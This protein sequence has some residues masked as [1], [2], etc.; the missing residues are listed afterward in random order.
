MARR[1]NMSRRPRRLPVWLIPAVCAVFAG[2]CI[3]WASQYGLTDA[4]PLT[5]LPS[6]QALPV[7]HADRPP[8][9]AVAFT[10]RNSGNTPDDTADVQT[11]IQAEE[12][13][14]DYQKMTTPL[15]NTYG[16]LSNGAFAV[17]HEDSLFYITATGIY[18]QTVSGGQIKQIAETPGSFL[19]AGSDWLYYLDQGGHI[20]KVTADGK[21]GWQLCDQTA[22]TLTLAGDWLYYTEKEDTSRLFR[23]RVD[24][25]GR[26][27]L[28]DSDVLEVCPYDGWL[29]CA[30][31]SSLFRMRPDGTGAETLVDKRC[32]YLQPQEGL[33]FAVRGDTQY[34]GTLIRIDLSTMDTTPLSEDTARCMLVSGETVYYRNDSKSG[35]LFTIRTNGNNDGRELTAKAVDN[36][37]LAGD[38]FF[39]KRDGVPTLCRMRTDGSGAEEL[40]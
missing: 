34:G 33:L 31:F 2:G 5:P 7:Y 13:D 15:G 10:V 11:D 25:T 16:N 29:Y 38:W 12:P 30:G 9:P 18:R 39:Y 36:L 32:V 27:Q 3:L 17:T 26:E 22:R 21:T 35:Y 28:T 4:A 24:G 20:Q 19:N 1:T 40:P 37:C 6:T 14:Q 8:V 23:I